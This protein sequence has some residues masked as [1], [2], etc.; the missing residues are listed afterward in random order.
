[1]CISEVGGTVSHPDETLVS[2]HGR[3]PEMQTSHQT[4]VVFLRWVEY[5]D[6]I[7]LDSG[8]Y[9]KS[10]KWGGGWRREGNVGG[11]WKRENYI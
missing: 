6:E 2:C 11:G 9:R 7:P 3:N 5:S 1:M 8:W 4:R 10:G